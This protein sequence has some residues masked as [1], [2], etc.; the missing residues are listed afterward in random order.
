MTSFRRDVRIQYTLVDTLKEKLTE[1]T[2]Y[3]NSNF[4]L[5]QGS[6][7]LESSLVL[8]KARLTSV[9]K[10]TN[11]RKPTINFITNQLNILNSLRNNI[12]IVTL[13]CNKNFGPAV[14]ERTI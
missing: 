14:R 8:F 9:Q 1:K 7:E 4:Q 5:D 13:M 10:T 2:I 6:I 12:G 3:I 11:K